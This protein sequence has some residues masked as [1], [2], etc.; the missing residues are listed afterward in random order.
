ML[1]GTVLEEND[2]EV[3][4]D[5]G[6]GNLRIPRAQVRLVERGAAQAPRKTLTKR[7]EWFLV[8]H[9]DKV[10]GWQHVVET[11]RD[12]KVVQAFDVVYARVP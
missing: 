9:R 2:E 7:D 11:V 6:A 1:R 10:I 3:V 5:M 12:G 4:I 8:L